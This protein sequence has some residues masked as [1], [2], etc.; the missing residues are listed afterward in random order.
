[1]KLIV[2]LG[3]PGRDYAGTRHN[4]GFEVVDVLAKRLHTRIAKR[5][6]RALIARVNTPGGEIILMKPQ[7]F[8]N[9]SGDA[10]AYLARREKIEPSEI[11]VIYDDMALPI[12]RIRMRPQG[13]A[14]GH[15]GMKSMIARLGTD[16]FPRLRVGIGSARHEAIEHV[17]SRFHPQEKRAIHDSIMRAADAAEAI[18]AEGLEAAMNRFNRDAE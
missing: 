2:G 9:L 6:G 12:G 15:N 4:V 18:L 5:M 3:N 14:G 7:T 1:L 8:M 10:V 11:L 16:E 13:S 17:L